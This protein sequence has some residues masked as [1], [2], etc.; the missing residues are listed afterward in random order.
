G[1]TEAVI[2]PARQQIANVDDKSILDARREHPLPLAPIDFE[3]AHVG[4][5]Y[6]REATVVRV[7]RD[8][9]LL[10]SGFGGLR[11]VIDGAAARDR[12]GDA[13]HEMVLV[14]VQRGG[15]GA[16]QP[17][18]DDMRRLEIADE[19]AAHGGTAGRPL[20]RR[21]QRA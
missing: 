4:L 10:A 15:K 7:R 19:S 3:A 18:A 21:E 11:R 20:V 8:A 6:E 1:G 14:Y 5:V 12:L 9:E 16:H 13:P 2:R 17:P